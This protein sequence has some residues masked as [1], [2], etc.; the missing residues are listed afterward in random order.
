L[1]RLADRYVS[2]VCV[3]V[4]AGVDVPDW[5]RAGLAELPHLMAASDQRAHQIDHAVVNLA[6][7]VVV[8]A[9]DDRGEIQLRNP[10]V[11]ARIDGTDLPLGHTISARL[12]TADVTTRRLVFSLA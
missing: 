2:E 3:A 6:E 7:A 4:C 1:R 10:A 11:G 12:T 9:D 5:A 8:E